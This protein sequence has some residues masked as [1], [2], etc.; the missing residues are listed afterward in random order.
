MW[1]AISIHHPL[2]EKDKLKLPDLYGENLLL[3]HRGWSHHVDDLRDD[4]RQNH[5]QIHIFLRQLRQ[6]HRS[7]K[8]VPFG[9]N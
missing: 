9:I 8:I 3:I 2:A 5:G 6:R 1:W 7:S 4:I